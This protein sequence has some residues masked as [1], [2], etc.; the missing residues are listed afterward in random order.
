MKLSILKSD[1][2]T[3]KEFIT[4][5]SNF[6]IYTDEE[7]YNNCIIKTEYTIDDIQSL[8]VWKNGMKLSYAKRDSLNNK[9]LPKIDY[10]NHLKTTSSWGIDDFNS[11]FGNV[12]FVWRIFLLHIIKPSEMP[13]YDQNVHRAYNYI[14]GFDFA[15][16]S[17]TLKESVKHS[18]YFDVY[19]PFVRSIAGLGMRQID[20]AFF[21]FGQ[22]IKNPTYLRLL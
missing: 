19:L 21:A 1:K 3:L 4:Y 12:S 2:T 9:I 13:I 6:Y 20:K 11:E 5:W 8:Y 14:H 15:T 17:E 10:I 22:F 7:L 18:F 16:V